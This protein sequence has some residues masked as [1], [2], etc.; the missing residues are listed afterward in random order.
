MSQLTR[1]ERDAMKRRILVQHPHLS[2]DDMH[3]AAGGDADRVHDPRT[4]Q[5]SEG[6]THPVERAGVDPGAGTRNEIGAAGKKRRLPV[7]QTLEGEKRSPGL[8]ATR[9]FVLR[10]AASDR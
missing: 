10:L 2:H 9:G 7:P 3:A 6:G 1:E 4:P 5:R 8:A